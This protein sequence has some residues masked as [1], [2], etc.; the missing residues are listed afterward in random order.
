MTQDFK[1]ES[2]IKDISRVF[3]SGNAAKFSVF[4]TAG[5]QI[6]GVTKKGKDFFKLETS[7]TE[8]IKSLHVQGQNLWSAGEYILN[9]YESVNNK[10]V[11]KYFYI[12]DDRI[13]DMV[14]TSVSGQ[15][16]LNPVI[17]CQDKT[18][19]VLIEGDKVLYQQK[20]DAACT[21]LILAN[22]QTHR[23]CP[24]VGYGLKNGGIGCIELTRDEPIVLW[25]LEGSQTNGSAAS[26]VKTCDILGEEGFHNFI[27][28]R[29][30]S[31]VEIYSYE[32]KSPI[33]IL[34]F[35]TKLDESITGIDVGFITN[36]QRQ[37]ILLS[38]Y[39]GKI[40][41]LV[42][43]GGLNKQ[44]TVAPAASEKMV[45]LQLQ[46]IKSE[47]QDKISTL[48]KEVELLKKK[49]KEIERIQEQELED[50]NVQ[51]AIVQGDVP[52]VDYGESFKVSYK[53][54][55]LPSE[56]AYSL[57]LD[58]Q[59][60]IDSVVL[61]SMQNIDII[62]AKDNICQINKI[63]DKINNNVLLATLKVAGD[64]SK[65]SRIEIK[66]R[67]S[68]GQTGHLNVIITPKPSTGNKTAQFLD[69]PL[70]PLNLHEK[71]DAVDENLKSELPLSQISINGKFSLT[72]AHNWIS[73]CLP[74]V[75]PNVS[76]DEQ[77]QV[78]T[79]YFKST[80]VGTFLFIELQK[81]KIIVESDNISVITII[82]D[83]LTSEASVKKIAI[84]I[85]SQIN[86]KSIFRTIELLHPLIQEQYTIAQKN[87]LIDGLKELQLQEEDNGFLSEE[88]KEILRNSDEIR[89]QFKQQP[90]K[91]TYLWGIIADLY[92]DTAKIKGHH[93]VGSRIT[94]LKQIL[95][96]YN[97]EELVSFFKHSW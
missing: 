94:Q 72:D 87:Q 73:N 74:D 82:K 42:D 75:P 58:S 20:F 27:V 85:E 32:H 14:V 52:Q 83:Q 6:R 22:E 70:R 7:H 11:D 16:V 19:K 64:D 63:E 68:E 40:M 5:Q 50:E 91:L 41:S 28:V 25:S 33:P 2:Q 60:P 39:S 35:E 17:A 92:M 80:F 31:S 23:Y 69:V 62:S 57:F 95:N 4:F 1:S 38:T 49:A 15:M 51:I 56:A 10:I 48:Q 37:E 12:C 30:D 81:A 44:M 55:I 3:I 67:T 78:H 53:L 86:D 36:P 65:S 77:D 18:L 97:Y 26:I 34:R 59:L 89:L 54:N 13:N 79:L 96:Q 29:D 9:C 43:K 66:I 76:S 88:Y 21:A 84:D 24:I 47:K 8:T 90:R 45:K 93:N 46:Q 71:I 61:Q